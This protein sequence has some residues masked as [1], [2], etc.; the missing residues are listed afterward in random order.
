[1][2]PGLRHI[3]ES[4]MQPRREKLLLVIMAKAPIPGEVK[5]RLLTDIT[6]AAATD[7]YCCFLQDRITE[8]SLLQGIDLAL[9]YTPEDAKT[10]FTAFPSLGFELFPQ[11]GQDLGERLHNI[12]VQKSIEGYDAIAI[13]DSDSPDLPRSIVQ[14]A[15]A[16]LTSGRAE[17]VFGPCFDGGYYLVGLLKPHPELFQEIPWST[18]LVLKKTLD[19]AAIENDN[20]K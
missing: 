1:M 19:I 12:L 13:L 6:P 20:N 4:L 2:L 17:A 14:E 18:A 16:L 15:F 11:S 9:A 3:L 5:T 8:M 10:Y 7:L